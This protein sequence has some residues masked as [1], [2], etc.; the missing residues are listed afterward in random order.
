MKTECT[1]DHQLLDKSEHAT[2]FQHC[3]IVSKAF[4]GPIVVIGARK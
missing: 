2:F 4:Q 3:E 1:E